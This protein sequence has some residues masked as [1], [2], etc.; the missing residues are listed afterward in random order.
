MM[1]AQ[2]EDGVEDENSNYQ[3]DENI[4]VVERDKTRDGQERY[5]L[6]LVIHKHCALSNDYILTAAASV[7]EGEPSTYEEAMNGISN[8]RER[9]RNIRGAFLRSLKKPPS[10]SGA[11]AKKKYYLEEF[12]HFLLPYIKNRSDDSNLQSVTD[13]V[14]DSEDE[15]TDYMDHPMESQVVQENQ[16]SNTV[17]YSL[18]EES[19][20]DLPDDKSFILAQKHCTVTK[21]KYSQNVSA[22]L[23]PADDDFIEWKKYKED[24]NSN[25]NEHPNMLFLRS[26]FPD[27]MK[28]TD[29]QN[30]RFRQKVIGLIDDIIEDKDIVSS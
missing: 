12:L 19:S 25:V 13:S 30:R 24:S 27:L 18:D 11:S 20:L 29:K 16:D 21:R 9:W 8:C 14:E 23:N 7:V 5:N 22:P 10:G 4:E 15:N 1:D 2:L 26:L 6:R 3:E 28:M 17:P